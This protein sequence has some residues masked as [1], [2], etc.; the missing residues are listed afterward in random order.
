[1]NCVFEVV[2]SGGGGDINARHDIDKKRNV[3]D[4]TL[5][6]IAFRY[7]YLIRDE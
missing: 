4:C 1:M 6:K 7:F 2:E 5:T 3:S